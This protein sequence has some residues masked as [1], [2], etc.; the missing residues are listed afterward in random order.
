MPYSVVMKDGSVK[1]VGYKKLPNVKVYSIHL[2][3]TCIGTAHNMSRRDYL[4]D[5]WSA[6][7][8]NKMIPTQLKVVDGLCSRLDCVEWLVNVSGLRRGIDE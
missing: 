6:V 2:D 7:S 5:R 1:D 3:G 4:S 8:Y